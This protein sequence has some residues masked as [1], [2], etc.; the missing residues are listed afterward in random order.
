[1][2]IDFEICGKIRKA[3]MCCMC[4]GMG[5]EECPM[6]A[7]RIEERRVQTDR[8]MGDRRKWQEARAC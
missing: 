6:T 3:Q 1:M 4:A 8:R 5:E 7:E 2:T